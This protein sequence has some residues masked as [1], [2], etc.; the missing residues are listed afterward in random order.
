MK[1]EIRTVTNK[2][3]LGYTPNVDHIVSFLKKFW[4]VK[5]LPK[6]YLKYRRGYTDFDGMDTYPYDDMRHA[7]KGLD[8]Q[9]A[10]HFDITR[11][12][13]APDVV[14]GN[15]CQGR[16]PLHTL[17]GAIFGYAFQCGYKYADLQ[18]DEALERLE[19]Y[20]GDELDLETV[21]L[22]IGI[23]KHL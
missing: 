1:Q 17:V 21:R 5:A 9:G 6:D 18:V 7:F 22:Y 13:S 16:S 10:G 4:N 11:Q 15:C 3:D 23:A 19:G 12:L 2:D 14:Y 8:N 20:L